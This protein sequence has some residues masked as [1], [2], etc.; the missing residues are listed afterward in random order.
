MSERVFLGLGSNLGDRAANL[1]AARRQIATLGKPG[2][3]STVYESPP[4]GVRL[5]QPDFLNQVVELYTELDAVQLLMTLQEIERDLGRGPHGKNE[6]RTIDV[7][8]LLYGEAEIALVAP[9]YT[10]FVPHPAMTER[11]F[12]LVP[13]LEIDPDLEHPVMGVRFRELIESVDTSAVKP[14]Y[15]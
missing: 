11:A 1:E 13:L 3:A 5:P 8:I 9:D 12:V 10:L 14:W 2:K 15:G 7:D 6:P 4:W